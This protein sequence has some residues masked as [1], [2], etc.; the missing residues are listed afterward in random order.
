MIIPVHWD[1]FFSPLSQPT[2]R[3]VR[4]VE[5]TE[6]VFFRLA[7]YCEKHDISLIVQVPRT[8]VEL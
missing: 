7:K 3:M 5:K 8:S 4:F 1:N 2:R 6:V